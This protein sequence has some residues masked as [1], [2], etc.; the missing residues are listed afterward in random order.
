MDIKQCDKNNLRKLLIDYIAC[1]RFIKENYA[2]DKKQRKTINNQVRMANM[3][4][5]KMSSV[6][7]DNVTTGNFNDQDQAKVSSI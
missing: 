7:D 4:I 1:A 3:Y 5:K 2:V 6:N